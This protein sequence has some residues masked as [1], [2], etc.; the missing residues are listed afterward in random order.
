MCHE[1]N[2][3]TQ[4][5]RDERIDHSLYSHLPPPFTMWDLH[6][7]FEGVGRN[8]RGTDTGNRNK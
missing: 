7:T 2:V 6:Q 4:L 1:K 5:I 8:P 3:F